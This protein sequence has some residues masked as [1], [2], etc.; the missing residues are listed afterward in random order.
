M[1]FIDEIRNKYLIHKGI[2]KVILNENKRE[3]IEWNITIFNKDDN[4]I[5]CRVDEKNEVNVVLQTTFSVDLYLGI[6]KIIEC[7][8]LF[9][10]NQYPLIIIE[11]K[12]S[13]GSGYLFMIMH[14]LF[15]MRTVDRMYLSFRMSNTSKEFYKGR[16]KE[17]NNIKTCEL[18][19]SYDDYKEITDHYNHHGLNVDHIRNE[20]V[21][22]LPFYYRSLLREFRE[23]YLNDESLKKYLKKSTDIILF[24]DSYSYSATC[25][26]IK[27]FQNT[28]G[29]II[30]GYFGNPKK[31]GIDLFDRCQSVS[32]V[33]T[34]NNFYLYKKLYNLGIKVVQITMGETFNDSIYD[35][36]PIPREYAFDP[37]DYRVNIFSSYSDDLYMKFIEE[38]KKIHAKFN[39]ENYCNSKNDKILLH[40]D[41]CKIEG[42]EH[43]HGGYKCNPDNNK[44]DT[45]NC[46]PYY[47]DIGYYFNQK[48][49]ECAKECSFNDT[50]LYFIYED[51]EE[52]YHIQKDQRAVFI[53]VNEKKNNYYFYNSTKDLFSGL[54]KIGFIGN[55]TFKID[56]DN[57]TRDNYELH[58]KKIE[59]DFEFENSFLGEM[60]INGIEIYNK[61]L[62]QISQLSEDHIFYSNGIFNKPGNKIKFGLYNDEMKPYDILLGNDKYFKEYTDNFITLEKDKINI[63][64][65][66]HLFDDQVH[67]MIG[68]KNNS[69]NISF[70]DEVIYILYLQK[71]IEYILDFQNFIIN[72]M[73]KLSR[74]AIDSEIIIKEENISLNSNN[75]YYQIKDDFNGKIK[76]VATK[77]DAIIEF[78][79]KMP[80][81]KVLDYEQLNAN[82]TKNLF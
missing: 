25:G 42:K 62:I 46:Q 52:T 7:A 21:D 9:H 17:R 39:K 14:Q 12:N 57:E 72:K 33:E 15:Q 29:A 63:I 82:Y 5:K 41:T 61:K 77:S 59:T 24:T 74:K 37:V 19:E 78:L 36:N 28:G 68:R 73:I 34:N 3:E 66:D 81:V 1:P 67:Y 13:G 50:K 27:G 30:V 35:L 56:K 51:I 6:A 11:S 54:P 47:C 43:A 58:I 64:Y 38:G 2:K 4:F 53:F 44:W 75:L 8:K 76:L 71:D 32:Q 22:S 26:L 10:T 48:T 65:I 69:K 80:E 23:K 49:K 31:E 55:R 18:V 16:I 45:N 40:S 79:F 70:E 20:A 60:D